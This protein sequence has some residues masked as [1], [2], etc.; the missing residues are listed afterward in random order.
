MIMVIGS[1]YHRLANV[2]VYH[3]SWKY[4][5]RYWNRFHAMA[6]VPWEYTTVY[7]SQYGQMHY[8]YVMNVRLHFHMKSPISSRCVIALYHHHGRSSVENLGSIFRKFNIA[9]F[10]SEISRNFRKFPKIWLGLQPGN[11]HLRLHFE[12]ALPFPAMWSNMII[13]MISN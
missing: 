9:R 2:V 10:F 4:N 5:N 13:I 6:T 8:C 11:H 1:K 7:Y 3:S 12:L